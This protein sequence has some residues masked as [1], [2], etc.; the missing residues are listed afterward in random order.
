MRRPIWAAALIA[1]IAFAVGWL[2][3]PRPFRLDDDQA[4][5]SRAEAPRL[6]ALLD[7]IADA[8]GT[9]R[10]GTV[11][12]DVQANAW[13]TQVGW[14][15]VPVVGIGLPLWFTLSSQERVALLAH[16]LGHGRN[17]DLRSAWMVGQAETILDELTA[18]FSEH[19]LDDFRHEMAGHPGAGDQEAYV[20]LVTRIVNA[21]VGRLVRGYA[22]LLER[23]E[24]RGSQRAEYLADRMAA[25]VAGSDAAARQLERLV[26]AASA[27]RALEKAL[28]FDRDAEPLA[29]VRRA[30]AEIPRR[31]VERRLRLSRLREARTDRTHPPTYLRAELIR[32][33]PVPT[34]AVVLGLD[35]S[36]GIDRELVAAGAPVLAELRRSF[37]V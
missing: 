34:A 21:T 17:G 14:R 9:E 16:E 18:T 4:T 10:V 24:L 3:R 1:A 35:D 2:F 27:D 6:Y 5:V 15:R 32:A 28:R 23:T 26:L 13:Y 22:W 33:R 31:E 30:I 19:P 36:A 25:E 7:Q 11:V 20:N 29:A 37:P 8:L 12:A